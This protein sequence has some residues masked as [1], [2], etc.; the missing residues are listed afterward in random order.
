LPAPAPDDTAAAAKAK[1]LQEDSETLQSPDYGKPRAGEEAESGK[2]AG[3]RSH[4]AAASNTVENDDCGVKSDSSKELES[5]SGGSKDTSDK[6]SDC[7][8]KE[9]ESADGS[10][11]D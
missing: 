6:G 5:A 9:L 8:A 11:E 3:G 4:G 2:S 10:G 7:S 1:Q